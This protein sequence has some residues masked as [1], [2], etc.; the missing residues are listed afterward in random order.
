MINQ[1]EFETD[2]YEKQILNL[3]NKY[4]VNETY[5]QAKEKPNFE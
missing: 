2:Y 3:R 4:S 1:N 5:K